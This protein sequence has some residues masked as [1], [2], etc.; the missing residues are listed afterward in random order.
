MAEPIPPVVFRQPPLAVLAALFL[1]VC[2]TPLAFAAP[3]LVA[4]YLLPLGLLAWLLRTR[5]V[6][7]PDGLRT[8]TLL[9]SRRLAWDELAGL[10][11]L[12]RG[13]VHAVPA[14]DDADELPLPAVR[15]RHLP[16]LAA[17]SGGR[18]RDPGGVETA[19]DQE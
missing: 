16:L 8:R 14:G 17:A 2:V 19:A 7:G 6:A 15:A 18:I 3:G 4:L 11:V 12:P 1:A 5:T 9:R 13:D 10:R